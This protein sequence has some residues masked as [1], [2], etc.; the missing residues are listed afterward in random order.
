M[1]SSWKLESSQTIQASGFG[2]TTVVSGRPTFPATSTGRPAAR[3]IA[4]RSSVVVVLPFVPGHAE[5]RVAGKEPV[6]ELDLAPDWHGTLARG[7]DERRLRRNPGAFHEQVHAVEERGV[8]RAESDFDARRAKPPRVELLVPVDGDAPRPRAR[9]A[10]ATPPR[11]SGRAR[12]RGRGEGGRGGVIMAACGSPL[13]STCTG[14]FPRWRPCS[15]SPTSRAADLVL[16]G[17]DTVAGPVP[18]ECLDLLWGLGDR[19]VMV[20]G[21]GERWSSRATAER[22]GAGAP[23]SSTRSGSPG[24]PRCPRP[25]DVEVDGLGSVAP[26]PRDAAQRRGDRHARDA[27]RASRGDR[28]RRRTPTSS[29]P[30]T[31]TRRWT[32]RSAACAG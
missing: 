28:R 14:I 25:R 9:R 4:P 27:G 29:S 31:R 30:V 10:R 6:A 18:A 24:S 22:G 12:R 26:L 16:C 13:S 8:V 23:T 32:G 11:P 19:L 21:N 7:G 20:H 3:K 2:S 1:S 5:D 15:R 17:G